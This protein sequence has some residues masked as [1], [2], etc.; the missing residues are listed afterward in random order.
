MGMQVSN[1]RLKGKVAIVTGGASGIGGA[2]VRLFAREGASVVIADINGERGSSLAAAL[3]RAGCNSVYRHTD[4][5]KSDDLA[6]AVALAEDRFG[7]LD[8]MV[9][10]AGMAGAASRKRLEGVTEDEWREVL[11]V[12]LMGVWRSFKHAIP[13]LRRAGGGA[14]TSTGSLAGISILGDSLLGV[15][16]AS[17]FGVVGLTQFMASE[18]IDDGIRVNCVCPGRVMTNIDESFGFTEP[19]LE[20]ARAARKSGVE[21]KRRDRVALPDEIAYLHL[22]LCSDEASYITGQAVLADGGARLFGAVGAKLRDRS[23]D[24][25]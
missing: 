13:A 17:K 6:A 11:D 25:A 24:P 7:R 20:G 1:G 3:N 14:M 5:S 18:L 19:D 8:I 4:V 12:N 15:Y 21:D 16:T 22:F 2:T 9:A 10:N 23:L